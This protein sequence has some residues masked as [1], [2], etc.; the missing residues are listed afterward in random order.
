MVTITFMIIT[1]III[2]ILSLA[3]S[4]INTG[5]CMVQYSKYGTFYDK[6]WYSF[7]ITSNFVKDG[8][9]FYPVFNMLN[10]HGPHNLSY[11]YWHSKRIILY[12][13]DARKIDNHRLTLYPIQCVTNHDKYKIVASSVMSYSRPMRFLCFSFS[14]WAVVWWSD[15]QAYKLG[16]LDPFSAV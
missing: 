14:Y 13:F 15:V 9:V 7:D 11:F 3:L 10:W 5:M 1:V 2:I 12:G 16:L 8:C 4:T 6:I